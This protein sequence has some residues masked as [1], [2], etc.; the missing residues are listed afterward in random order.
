MGFPLDHVWLAAA[1]RDAACARV[2]AATGLAVQ[3]AWIPDGVVRSRG[4]RF[5]GGVFLDVHDLD[6]AGGRPDAPATAL[7]RGSIAQA[8]AAAVRRGWATVLQ[9][10]GDAPAEARPPW[11]ILLFRRG[12]GVISHLAVIEY[13][14][15]PKDSPVPQFATPLLALDSAPASG[16]SVRRAWIGRTPTPDEAADLDA[17]GYAPAG[18]AWRTEGGPELGL[19]DGAGVVRLEADGAAAARVT[20]G[21]VTLVV[22]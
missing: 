10:A 4:V 20:V 12:Q 9:R 22:G 6:A 19:C 2:A 16:P 14:I 17:L 21:P 5:A 11:S 18:P 7:L 1:D 3:D 13:E 15:D 8:E